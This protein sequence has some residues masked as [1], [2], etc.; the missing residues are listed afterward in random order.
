MAAMKLPS[1]LSVSFKPVG[2]SLP[3][4]HQSL[5]SDAPIAEAN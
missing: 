4:K 3:T 5:A 1:L 2:L